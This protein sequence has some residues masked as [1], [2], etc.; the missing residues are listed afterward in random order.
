MTPDEYDA[1]VQRVHGWHARVIE[2][3]ADGLTFSE[4]DQQARK[5]LDTPSRS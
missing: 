3:Q 5:E 2:L 4:A 1:W